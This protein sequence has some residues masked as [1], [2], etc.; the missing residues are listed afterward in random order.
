VLAIAEVDTAAKQVNVTIAG[1]DA[2]GPLS[3]SRGYR[4]QD[5]DTGY[6]LD[7]AGVVSLGVLEGRWKTMKTGP[8]GTAFGADVLQIDVVFQ[9]QAEWNDMRGRILDVDGVDNVNIG[10]L[11]ARSA[12]LGLTY[13]GGG[14]ALATVLTQQGMTLTQNGNRWSLRPGS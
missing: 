8:G 3:W 11:S 7:L 10:A 2:V 4:V 6:A 1:R 12:E 13:S 14:N 5:G 9:S